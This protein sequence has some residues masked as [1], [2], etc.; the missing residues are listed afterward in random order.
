MQINS[1]FNE[2]ILHTCELHKIL[3]MEGAWEHLLQ[4][5]SLYR[6]LTGP[7]DLPKVSAV[8]RKGPKVP[9]SRTVWFCCFFSCSAGDTKS[10][11]LSYIVSPGCATKE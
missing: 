1:A 9:L 5:I 6:K 11:P 8:G 7:I 10:L 3:E 4:L 2:H